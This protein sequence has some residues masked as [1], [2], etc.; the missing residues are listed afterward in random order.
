MYVSKGHANRILLI[1][2]DPYATNPVTPGH[3][4]RAPSAPPKKNSPDR[5]S[6]VRRCPGPAA[7]ADRSGSGGCGPPRPGA[8]VAAA[9]AAAARTPT[10]TR[11]SRRQRQSQSLRETR[12][13]VCGRGVRDCGRGESESARQGSQSMRETGES[14][15]AGEGKSEAE[16]RRVLGWREGS[17]RL[18]EVE[19]D[20]RV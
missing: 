15:S 20:N 12:V 18:R 10:R 16:A 2:Q 17:Q 14:E 9:A 19:I 8:S 5:V 4:T 1:N 11:W 3:P 6:V 7:G 13:R